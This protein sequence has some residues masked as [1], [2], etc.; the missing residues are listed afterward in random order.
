MPNWVEVTPFQNEK[1]ITINPYFIEHPE[2]VLGTLEKTSTAYGFDLTCKP[3]E[4]LSLNET[5]SERMQSLPQVYLPSATS[6]P[7]PQQIADV[8]DKRP[9]SFYIENGEIKFYDGF[10]TENVKINAK[11]REKMLLAMKIRDYVRNVLDVQVN[12]GIDIQLEVAQGKLNYAYEKYVHHYGRICEDTALKKIFS[13]DSAYPLLRSLEV[14]DK[15]GFKEKSPI[16]SQRMIEPHRQP[17]YAENPV[18]AL[19]IS[20]QEFGRVSIDYMASLTGTSEE[21]IIKSLEFERIYF[22]FQKQEYQLAEEFLS[23]D[24]REKMDQTQFQ[25]QRIENEINAKL[26]ASILQIEDI[27][28]YEP[29]NEIEKNILRFEINGNSHFSFS[30]YLDKEQ[31]PHYENYIKSQQDNLAFM[32]Q[33]VLRQGKCA[34]CDG[35]SNILADKPLLSLEAIRLGREIAYT[36]AADL[37]ILSSIRALGEDFKYD[38][39]EHD[40]ILYSFLKERLA[41]FEG[42]IDAISKEINS[43]YHRSP[44]NDINE[45]WAQYKA[46]YQK[47]KISKQD[48][49]NPEI[50]RLRVIKSRLEKNFAAL[51]NVKPKDLTA[52]DIHVEIGATWIPPEDIRRFIQ[53]TFD[54]SSSGMQVHFSQ[55]TGTW[56][57]EG[58]SHSANPKIDCTC[59]N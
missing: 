56:R 31:N 9:S 21:E 23:G 5:L 50:E 42:N 14:Y 10:K 6:L 36:R 16:F 41:K 55:I 39:S 37:I 24:I 7:L 3:D 20:M 53:E 48:E 40:L 59:F 4:K 13:K 8:V 11:D 49:P 2:D 57:I 12:D 22:D 38:K 51:E 47:L 45:K 58:K 32:L 43:L 18:D 1:D 15:K 26:A 25:I 30:H 28:K 34:E 19:A 33:V 29:Q 54:V 27:P 46:E 44:D 35:V 52:A 17:T